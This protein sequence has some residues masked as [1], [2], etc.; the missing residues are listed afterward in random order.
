MEGMEGIEGRRK[1]TQSMYFLSIKYHLSVYILFS[2]LFFP[3]I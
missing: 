1:E 2:F 3:A